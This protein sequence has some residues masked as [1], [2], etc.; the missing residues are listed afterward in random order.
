VKNIWAI[1]A[2]PELAG[3]E[4][5]KQMEIWRAA[6]SASLGDWKVWVMWLGF[7][8]T[9]SLVVAQTWRPGESDLEWMVKCLVVGMAAL[10]VVTP[11]Q[12]AL[13]RP[14]IRRELERRRQTVA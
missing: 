9:F 12:I 7:A 13:T 5:T 2:I 11:I 14:Y 10:L 6:T 4:R 1:S 3:M 8:L